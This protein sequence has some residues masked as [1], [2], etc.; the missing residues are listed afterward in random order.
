MKIQIARIQRSTF[1]TLEMA[2]LHFF[3]KTSTF[4]QKIFEKLYF[5]VQIEEK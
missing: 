3:C 2:K 4:S 5:L 1:R